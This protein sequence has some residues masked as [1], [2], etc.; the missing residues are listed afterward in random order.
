MTE[1]Q[2]VTSWWIIPPPGN[3]KLWCGVERHTYPGAVFIYK[4]IFCERSNLLGCFADS[5]I[6]FIN[7]AMNMSFNLFLSRQKSIQNLRY[8]YHFWE[9][10]NIQTGKEMCYHPVINSKNAFIHLPDLNEIQHLFNTYY[11]VLRVPASK[12]FAIFNGQKVMHSTNIDTD[13]N[14]AIS[15]TCRYIVMVMKTLTP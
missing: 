14:G 10:C 5:F 3:S 12:E 9:L 6:G 1:E 11:I 4:T 8:Q 15:L 13:Q 7:A 2:R